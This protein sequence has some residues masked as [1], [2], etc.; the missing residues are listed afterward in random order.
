M[1]EDRPGM[2]DRHQYT[3]LSGA[4]LCRTGSAGTREVF[5]VD[6][7]KERFADV[8]GKPKYTL[9][10]RSRKTARMIRGIQVPAV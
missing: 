3:A 7:K 4:V 10:E 9:L 5:V 6:V 8:M 2:E 1:E